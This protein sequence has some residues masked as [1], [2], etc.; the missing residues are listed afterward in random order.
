MAKPPIKLKPWSVG[1][2]WR[3]WDEPT[4]L[5][6]GCK[7]VLPF[8]ASNKESTPGASTAFLPVDS[9]NVPGTG[10]DPQLGE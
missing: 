8:S 4:S 10:F 7:Q 1:N 9:D 2:Q 3:G 5:L 6:G